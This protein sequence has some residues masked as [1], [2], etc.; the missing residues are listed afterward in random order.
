[1]TWTDGFCSPTG[2]NDCLKCNA[3]PTDLLPFE[4]D[5]KSHRIEVTCMYVYH[6]S[7]KHDRKP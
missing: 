2:V 3:I 4:V 6:V 5:C 1:M 7:K